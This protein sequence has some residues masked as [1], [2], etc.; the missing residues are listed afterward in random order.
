MH[1][2]IHQCCEVTANDL[3]VEPFAV[4]TEGA[5]SHLA[6]FVRRC[7]DFAGWVVLSALLVLMPKCPA[8][9]AAYIAI[10]TGLGLSITVATHFRILLIILSVGS[11]LLMAARQVRRVIVRESATV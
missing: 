11:L 5:K 9:F 10:G 7:L 8:C 2:T 3:R 4:R 1:M 6:T